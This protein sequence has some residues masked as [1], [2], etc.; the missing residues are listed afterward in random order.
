M[1]AY[2]RGGGDLEGE[3]ALRDVQGD[4]AWEVGSLREKVGAVVDG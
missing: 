2:M 3:P 1:G 4:E